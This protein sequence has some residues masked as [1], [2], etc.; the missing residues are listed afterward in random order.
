MHEAEVA[1]VV[2]G[3][4]LTIPHLWTVEDLVT[5]MVSER[6]LVA[7][8]LNRQILKKQEWHLHRLRDSDQLEI[9]YFVGGG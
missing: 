7:V 5:K 8:E 9:V 1:I 2:N 4:T 6:G 3:D